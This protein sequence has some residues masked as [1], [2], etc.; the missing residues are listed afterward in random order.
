M[1]TVPP[2]IILTIGLNLP[3]EDLTYLVGT[4]KS[5]TWL[6]TDRNFWNLKIL[7]QTQN[8]R[9]FRMVNRE[10]YVDRKKFNP[11][12]DDLRLE[13][14]KMMTYL[15][16][17]YI[18]GMEKF[19]RP[20]ET[21]MR[22]LKSRN[23]PIYLQMLSKDNPHQE[24]NGYH[25]DVYLAIKHDLPEVIVELERRTALSI[26]WIF[27]KTGKPSTYG[28]LLGFARTRQVDKFKDLFKREFTIKNVKNLQKLTDQIVS[29]RG[30]L[31][32]VAKGDAEFSPP[33]HSGDFYK[34][35]FGKF[36]KLHSS[37]DLA[38]YDRNKC[39]HELG[40]LDF[41][42]SHNGPADMLKW[43]MEAVVSVKNRN[44]RMLDILK[45]MALERH[46]DGHDLMQI[47]DRGLDAAAK[48]GDLDMVKHFVAMG[49]THF[50]HAIIPAC[51]KTHLPI[52]EY[53]FDQPMI[54]DRQRSEPPTTTYM[55][56][57]GTVVS[58]G[59]QH[60]CCEAM[61]VIFRRLD[62]LN[63]LTVKIFDQVITRC[64][65]ER[66]TKL[67]AFTCQR[68][69]LYLSKDELKDILR[70]YIANGIQYPSE[71]VVIRCQLW[72]LKQAKI[73]GFYSG[74]IPLKPPKEPR[75][76]PMGCSSPPLQS[77][78]NFEKMLK[79]THWF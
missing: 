14:V 16:K 70:S 79:T 45:Q 23:V 54:F 28:R 32:L 19:E 30:I 59:S 21:R 65:L 12:A 61:E 51:K 73:E 8:Y 52:L 44:F 29:I 35:V 55:Y 75:T 40:D 27:N 58:Y 39:H 13:Y 66:Y 72:C 5:F 68:I 64:T 15:V 37:F 9:L 60:G 24:L 1:D 10:Q 26:D 31:I 47:Y 78:V 36:E 18:P 25:L 57:A 7:S 3:Y 56:D 77:E 53:L 41:T 11:N 33:E 43:A 4:C 71:Q 48:S 22:A 63:L 49:A 20:E 6:I 69:K 2:P 42:H 67:F 62:N 17:T 74:Q 38:N 76:Y 46:I 34:W 50:E